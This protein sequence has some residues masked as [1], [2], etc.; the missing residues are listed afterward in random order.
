VIE[1][2][3]ADFTPL[4]DFPLLWRWTRDSHNRLTALTLATIRPLGAEAAAAVAP[5]AVRLCGEMAAAGPESALATG[6]K[7]AAAVRSWLARLD[8]PDG[9]DVV[10]S[11]SATLAIVTRWE[12][13]IQHW[14]A[15]CYP[16]SDDVTVG[17]PS[18]AWALCYH[19]S[20][21]FEFTRRRP[22][23]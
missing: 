16:A 17:A 19:H 3:A 4:D 20:E 13:F 11:W 15:F 21:R 10:V 14:D 22:A 9:A 23:T 18:G 6:D 7:D 1:F 8:G 2:S 5:E 12:T